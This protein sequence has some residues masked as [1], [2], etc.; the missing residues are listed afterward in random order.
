[1]PELYDIELPH[2]YGEGPR[3]NPV[4]QVPLADLAEPLLEWLDREAGSRFDSNWAGSFPLPRIDVFAPDGGH[5]GRALAIDRDRVQ[6]NGTDEELALQD[7]GTRMIQAIEKGEPVER[8]DPPKIYVEHELNTEGRDFAVGDIHAT[9]DKVKALLKHVAFDP[10]RDRLFAVGD[11]QDRGYGW[12]R[13]PHYVSKDWFHCIRGNHDQMALDGQ[14]WSSEWDSKE[15]RTPKVLAALQT[16]PYLRKVTT[17]QGDIGFAHARVPEGLSWEEAVAA[18][19]TGRNAPRHELLWDGI[20]PGWS[21]PEEV[22]EGV[23]W[24]I[25]GHKIVGKPAVVQNHINIDTGGHSWTMTM[26]QFHPGPWRY[27]CTKDGESVEERDWPPEP[28]E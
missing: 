11:L 17:D 10:S 27:W 13:I 2:P 6:L 20:M 28:E 8:R 1:M 18:I 26:I 9:F 19:A 14:I 3:A 25:C 5:V 15:R 22:V 23:T 24:V 21:E 4:A 7:T 12:K 16:M